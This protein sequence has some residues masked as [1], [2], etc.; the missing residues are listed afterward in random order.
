[1][2]SCHEMARL[3]SL[4]HERELPAVT[5]WKMSLHYLI[6]VWCRRYRD[7]MRVLRGALRRLGR[8][9]DTSGPADS[10]PAESRARIKQSLR[11]D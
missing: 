10:L 1:M 2:F 7:Q 9:T 11:R 6:C 8:R 4:S 3:V 5:R